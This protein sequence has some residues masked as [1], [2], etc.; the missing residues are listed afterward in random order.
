MVSYRTV[1]L[2]EDISSLLYVTGVNSQPRLSC[3]LM[4]PCSRVRL[5]QEHTMSFGGFQSER[6]TK[7]VE[8]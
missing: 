3:L 6:I 4:I 8:C 5:P 1:S 7:L 2:A